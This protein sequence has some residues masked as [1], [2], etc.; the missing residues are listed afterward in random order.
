MKNVI[1]WEEYR[2]KRQTSLWRAGTHTWCMIF[3][4]SEGGRVQHSNLEKLTDPE[5]NTQELVSWH[6]L[7]THMNGG[8]PKEAQWLQRVKAVLT[9]REG[10]TYRVYLQEN[11]PIFYLIIC[12]QLINAARQL[13]GT[14]KDEEQQM[15]QLCHTKP[16]REKAF[17]ILAVDK[18]SGLASTPLTSP[19]S[20]TAWADPERGS[21]ALGLYLGDI[22]AKISSFQLTGKRDV[23]MGSQENLRKFCQHLGHTELIMKQIQVHANI[24]HEE[25]FSAY[26]R[27]TQTQPEDS[28]PQRSRPWL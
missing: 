3:I 4:H 10:V 18:S 23:W 21:P 20:I 28:F 12:Y 17:L 24:T 1:L 26:S 6:L 22:R 8:A 9:V 13:Q 27:R 5:V 16:G 7:E 19:M 25:A 15:L 14:D 11:V 2:A